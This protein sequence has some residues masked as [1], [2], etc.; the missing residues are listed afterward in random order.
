[1]LSWEKIYSWQEILKIAE[2]NFIIRKADHQDSLNDLINGAACI[3]YVPGNY[4]LLQPKDEP[5]TIFDQIGAHVL[6]KSFLRQAMD[7]TDQELSS[8]SFLSYTPFASEAIT[9]VDKGNIQAAFLLKPVSMSILQAVC[10][11]G[12]VMPRKSTYFYPK[13]PTG[14]LF[15]LWH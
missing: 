3:L 9:K 2:K 4:Y 5:E 14:L 7:L 15:Y 6:D 10:Q 1:M 8:G 11:S 13:L 12:Q